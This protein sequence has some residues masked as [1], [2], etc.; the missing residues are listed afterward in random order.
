MKFKA[1]II[2]ITKINDFLNKNDR[3]RK[4]NKSCNYFIKF[5]ILW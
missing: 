1:K 3:F 2:I 4:K 5:K